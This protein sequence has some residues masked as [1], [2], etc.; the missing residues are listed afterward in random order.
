[1]CGIAAPYRGPNREGPSLL[2]LH[3]AQDHPHGPGQTAPILLFRIELFGSGFGQRIELRFAAVHFT[4]LGL[5]Q[6]LL[7][8]AMERRVKRALLY[9]QH[10]LRDLVDALGDAVSVDR[11]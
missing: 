7:L 1:P 2:L 8:D 9:L 5:E 3:G 4:P 10:F 6:A 11:P